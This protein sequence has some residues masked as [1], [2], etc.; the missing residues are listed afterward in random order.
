MKHKIATLL[1]WIRER[2]EPAHGL[3]IPI[4]GGS[5][6][7]LCF[8][9]CNQVCPERTLGVYFGDSLRCR[10]W[11]EDQ[12]RFEVLSPPA[13]TSARQRE[14]Q[15]WAVLLD[16]GLMEERWLAG[17]R[18][19]TEDAFGTYSLASR[20]ATFLPLAGL[21]KTEVIELCAFA[22]VP[23]AVTDSSRKADPD[24][25]RPKELADVP[26]EAIDLFLMVRVG[27]LPPEA[28]SALTVEQVQYLDRIYHYNQFKKAL[29]ICG[30]APSRS[31]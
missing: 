21:W 14:L 25:G 23:C 5:D 20:L 6:S 15:R 10:D 3:L 26:L 31:S 27:E 9:L 2:A 13:G 7:A 28:L 16:K 24:C 1:H 11:F 30:P 12:G 29:P 19:R 18:N 4:S 22:G 8:W 17:S